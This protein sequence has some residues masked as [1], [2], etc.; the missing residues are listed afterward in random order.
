MDLIEVSNKV[1]PFI[2]KLGDLGK[3]RYQQ[4][5]ELKKQKQKQSL[6]ES[7][8]VQI[9]FKEGPHDLA[10]KMRKLEEF[11]EAGKKVNVV[12]RLRGREK[13]HKDLAFEKFDYFLKMIKIPY[14]TIQDKKLSPNGII[15]TIKK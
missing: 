2:Y 1:S 8:G 7:K 6:D 13:A 3:Y 5:K 11:L 4:A 14:K 12:M 15:A 9:G 10:Y